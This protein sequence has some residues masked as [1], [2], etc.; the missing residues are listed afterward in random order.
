VG[1]ASKKAECWEAFKRKDIALP[2]GWQ[3]DLADAAFVTPR[4]E[5]E[6]MEAAWE[7]LRQRFIAD[8]RTVEALEAYTGKEWVRTRR[9]DPVSSYAVLTWEQLR[10]R[11]A[12]GL[13][14][15]RALVEMMAIAAQE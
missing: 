1:E 4:T 6:A 10:S 7:R 5:E 13:K 8:V 15:I 14:K 9:R 11:P 12:L 2:A 3:N